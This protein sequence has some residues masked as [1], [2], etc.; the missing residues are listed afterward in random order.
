MKYVCTEGF[1]VEM[2]DGD[3]FSEDRYL[4]IYEGEVYEVDETDFRMIGRPDSIRM[5]C[6][7]GNWLELTPDYVSR[8][9]SPFED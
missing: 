5:E 6:E 8:F 9:F 7:N 4:D 1:S 2:F 3:G